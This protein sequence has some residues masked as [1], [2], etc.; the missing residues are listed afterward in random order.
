M[1]CLRA[2]GLLR[3]KEARRAHIAIGALVRN[4]AQSASSKHLTSKEKS[5]KHR[6]LVAAKVFVTRLQVLVNFSANVHG[7]VQQFQSLNSVD[8]HF[9]QA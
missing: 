3:P 7:Q 8:W 1:L 5:S 4:T 9:Q 2:L 6:I